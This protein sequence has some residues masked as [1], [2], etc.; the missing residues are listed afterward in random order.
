MDNNLNRDYSREY[1]DV[2]EYNT[3]KLSELYRDKSNIHRYYKYKEI[4]NDK[5]LSNIEE[6]IKIKYINPNK[7]NNLKSSYLD[8]KGIYNDEQANRFI[9]LVKDKLLEGSQGKHLINHNNY[10]EGNSYLTISNVKIKEL[11]NNYV[12]LGEKNIM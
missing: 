10:I 5:A 4:L 9:N 11:V 8:E 2:S 7:W 6:F 3:T 1:V 12:T